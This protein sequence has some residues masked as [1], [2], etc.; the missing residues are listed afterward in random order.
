[1]NLKSIA[2][3]TLKRIIPLTPTKEGFAISLTDKSV[4]IGLAVA[5]PKYQ[6]SV[7]F[8]DGSAEV[9]ATHQR[10][11]IVATMEI[12]EWILDRSQAVITLRP[13]APLD[14]HGRD[15]VGRVTLF[16]FGLIWGRNRDNNLM[17][18]L[19]KQYPALTWSDGKLSCDLDAVPEIHKYLRAAVAGLQVF[20]ILDV[21]AIR[22]LPGVFQIEFRLR[23]GP[24]E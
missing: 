21:S 7:R 12:T 6:A 8:M 18:L 9:S 17:R 14:V 24:K 10:A 11:Q 15:I 20:D 3:Q 23:T 13:T 1:M 2:V 19:G 4:N 16:V 22:F 5:F